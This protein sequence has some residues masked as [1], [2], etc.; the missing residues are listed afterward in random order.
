M[1]RKHAFA[2]SAQFLPTIAISLLISV[3]DGVLR[4]FPENGRTYTSYYLDVKRV[5]GIRV[6]CVPARKDAS[7]VGASRDESLIRPSGVVRYAIN[8]FIRL[9][10][11]GYKSRGKFKFVV[12]APWRLCR[13]Y[14]RDFKSDFKPGWSLPAL[15]RHF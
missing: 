3:P 4:P 13:R 1:A 9:L 5:P 10:R 14:G 12:S 2:C 15:F 6:S 8:C 11:H 7:K